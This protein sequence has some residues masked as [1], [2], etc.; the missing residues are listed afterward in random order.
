MPSWNTHLEAGRRLADRFKISGAKR[1]EFLLGCILPDINNGYINRVGIKKHHHETHYAYNDKSTKNFYAR[2][3]AKIT[4]KDPIFLG[5]L[6]HLY[7][8][9]FFNHTFYREI[10]KSSLK[11][12]VPSEEWRD[13]KHHDFWLFDTKFRHHLGIKK[14]DLVRVAEHANEIDVVEI[15]PADIENVEAVLTDESFNNRL[16]K[17]EYIFYSEKRLDDLLEET[18]HGFIRD[19]LGGND[20]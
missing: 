16:K 2:N 12:K 1:Q 6:F 10:K 17:T 7:T 14:Q 8:D 15:T 4:A 13:I 9:G 3:K 19:Y 11:D 20:A 5:Y 18:I